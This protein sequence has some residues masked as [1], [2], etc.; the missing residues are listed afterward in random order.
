[1]LENEVLLCSCNHS[2]PK[3]IHQNSEDDLFKKK[4]LVKSEQ[5][6]SPAK[7]SLK[8]S[9]HNSEPNEPHLC[10]CKKAKKKSAFL[11]SFVTNNQIMEK[12]QDLYPRLIFLCN[13]NLLS[14]NELSGFQF[15]HFR[16]PRY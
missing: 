3:E 7:D 11:Q 4:L 14:E 12:K 2:S 1:M 13:L 6:D 10:M 5:D 9:C 16:P 8:P 15:N